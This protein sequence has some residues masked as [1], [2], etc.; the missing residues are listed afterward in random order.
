MLFMFF[1]SKKDY[2]AA[3]P[4]RAIPNYHSTSNGEKAENGVNSKRRE[5]SPSSK[6]RH[7]KQI[8]KA[9]HFGGRGRGGGNLNSF[10]F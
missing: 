7:F 3:L 6:E 1:R 4:P 9:L 5:Q 8:T 10:H 2:N